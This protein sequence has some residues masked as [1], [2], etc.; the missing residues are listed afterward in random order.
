MKDG[1]ADPTNGR[2][3]AGQT[4]DRLYLSALTAERD[5]GTVAALGDPAGQVTAALE[6]GRA[7]L[8]GLG[9]S[10]RD[11]RKVTVAVVERDYLAAAMAELSRELTAPLARSAFV[12]AGLSRPELLV[13]LDI[14]AVTDGSGT[15]VADRNAAAG[16]QIVVSEDE[17]FVSGHAAAIG[18]AEFGGGRRPEDAARQAEAA[19]ARL[20][21]LLATAGSGIE[22]IC[23]ITVQVIDRAYRETVYPVIGRYFDGVFPVSTGLIVQG[24]PHPGQLFQIDVVAVPRH[25]APHERIRKYH[26]SAARYGTMVQNLDC[27][28]CMAVRAGQKVILRGQTGVDLDER[29]H[30]IGDPA[31]QTDQAM[32]N[33]EALLREAG[34]AMRDIAKATLYVTDRAYLAPAQAV[35]A[36]HLDG[37]GAAFSSIIVKG[38]ASPEQI[39]EVDVTAVTP[40]AGPG[41]VAAR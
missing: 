31:R 2:T 18:T 32:R 29:M 21:A 23:K 6:R 33:I 9:R 20:T 19:L 38:L 17:L 40:S 4:G 27:G 14:E 37:I 36:R 34:A 24:L 30:G 26:T 28:F 13:Q 15:I 11:I 8:A 7:Q 16:T 25:G 22:D 35:V 5:D 12:A 39:I 3:R 10:K 41:M 1:R